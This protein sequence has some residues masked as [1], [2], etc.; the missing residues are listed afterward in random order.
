[1]AEAKKAQKPSLK[2]QKVFEDD[3]F[4]LGSLY[5][6]YYKAADSGF[7]GEGTFEGAWEAIC[8]RENLI[9]PHLA[10]PNANNSPFKFAWAHAWSLLSSAIPAATGVSMFMMPTQSY[11]NYWIPLYDQ[12]YPQNPA[13]SKA[14]LTGT[15]TTFGGLMAYAWSSVEKVTKEDLTQADETVSNNDNNILYKMINYK[16]EQVPEEQRTKESELKT[17]KFSFGLNKYKVVNSQFNGKQICLQ[18]DGNQESMMLFKCP[19]GIIGFNWA[20]SEYKGDRMKVGS[21]KGIGSNVF[22]FYNELVDRELIT[23][24]KWE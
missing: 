3:T 20:S 9:L 7:G 22:T 6:G 23:G 19:E 11:G 15:I 13:F 4:D 16:N 5:N 18:A 2:L 24:D 21:L 12:S 14:T 1:M 8:S 17:L 10:Y